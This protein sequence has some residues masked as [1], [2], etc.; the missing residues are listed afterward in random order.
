MTR[1]GIYGSHGRMGRAIAAVVGEMGTVTASGAD[2]GDDPVA[3][4]RDSDVLVDFSAPG[5][6]EAH[7]DAARAHRRPIL[8]GTTGLNA[9][10]HALIDAAAGEVAVLQTG[11]TSLGVALLSRLVAEAAA[12]LG[13]DWDIEI[14][15][16]H[17]RE[18]RDAPSGTALMLGEAAARGIG[19]TLAETAVTGRAGLTGARTP[20][21]IGFASMRGGT[22]V[23]DHVVLF[24]GNGERIELA[25]RADD[26]AIFAQGAVRA[27]LWLIDQPPGRFAMDAVLGL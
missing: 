17:H 25:H 4:A 8:V 16:A 3:L 15:E 20:G 2:A 24:A 12:R 23:G 13:P 21:T 19:S 27:A 5:A 7:L 18:K 10:H 6:L 14:V 11:N 22:I 26:R 1:I 9:Q